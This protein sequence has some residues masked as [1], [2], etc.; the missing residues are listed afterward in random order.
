MVAP[1]NGPCGLALARRHARSKPQHADR[2]QSARAKN[3]DRRQISKTPGP[4]TNREGPRNPRGRNLWA[5][6][7]HP[8]GV[9]VPGGG[10]DAVALAKACSTLQKSWGAPISGLASSCC[11]TEP[12]GRNGRLFAAAASAGQRAARRGAQCGQMR[13]GGGGGRWGTGSI[14][15]SRRLANVCRVTNR[16][17]K[18]LENAP[19]NCRISPCISSCACSFLLS[20][21]SPPVS[22]AQ[23]WRTMGTGGSETRA[24]SGIASRETR[25]RCFSA[26]KA[27]V[28]LTS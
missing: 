18:S 14:D 19:V 13:V 4:N 8:A 17:T 26:P 11:A 7:P 27:C 21:L 1:P 12:V 24:R 25:G 28:Q 23:Q 20:P 9:G 3:G 2:T 6:G 22:A 16:L 5:Q 10:T 15:W